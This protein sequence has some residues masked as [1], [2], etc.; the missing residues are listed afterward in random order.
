MSELFLQIAVSL[1]GYIEDA[2]GDIDWMVFDASVDPY[3]TQTLKSIDCMIFGR[4]P[5]PCSPPSGPAPPRPR[6][7]HPSSWPRPGS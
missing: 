4:K 5:M 7:P 1:N 6:V 3:A 2:N